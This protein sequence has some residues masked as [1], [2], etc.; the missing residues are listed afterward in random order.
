MVEFVDPNEAMYTDFEPKNA[1][2]FIMYI[3][4][5]PSAFLKKCGRPKLESGEVELP[6]INVTRYVK[7]KSKWQPISIEMYDFIKPSGMQMVMEW[8]R[9]S[10]EPETGRDGYKDMYAKEITINVLGPTLDVQEE[11][12]LKGA[13]AKSF[14]G[15]ELD[16][17]SEDLLNISLEV[18]YDW[19]SMSF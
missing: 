18:R 2:R 11:W 10:H 1:G 4:G 15:G 7:G 8:M 17:A 19:A 5:I 9:L 3:D 12:I 14:D 6:H 16:W 13:W